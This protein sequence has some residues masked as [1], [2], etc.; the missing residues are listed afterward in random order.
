MVSNK[1]SF[2]TY[3]TKFIWILAW[4]G[5]TMPTPSMAQSFYTGHGVDFGWFTDD[6]DNSWEPYIFHNNPFGSGVP[7]L[8]VIDADDMTVHSTN[9]SDVVSVVSALATD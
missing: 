6:E 8:G 3:G 5:G 1:S 4:D 2:D 7:W 9:P